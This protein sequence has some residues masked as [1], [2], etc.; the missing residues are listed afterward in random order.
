MPDE[1]LRR[2]VI[3]RW[4]AQTDSGRGTDSSRTCSSPTTT[5]LSSRGRTKLFA[6]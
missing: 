3:E 4:L 1:P 2:A 6:L 5:V